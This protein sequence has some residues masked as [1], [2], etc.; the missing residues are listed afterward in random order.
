MS[1][2]NNINSEAPTSFPP[3]VYAP[4]F[5]FIRP[6][7]SEDALASL[8]NAMGRGSLKALPNHRKLVFSKWDRRWIRE[9]HRAGTIDFADLERLPDGEFPRSASQWPAADLLIEAH[10]PPEKQTRTLI[11]VQV[12]NGHPLPGRLSAFV[13]LLDN[14]QWFA[15]EPLTISSSGKVEFERRVDLWHPLLQAQ[16]VDMQ[17]KVVGAARLIS[18]RHQFLTATRH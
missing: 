4:C 10:D 1:D 15:V 2:D 12:R 18:E 3:Q 11:R 14:R 5:D 17:E 6:G 16:V 13:N 7:P 8:D 9:A